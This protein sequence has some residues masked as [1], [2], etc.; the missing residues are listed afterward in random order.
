[1]YRYSLFALAA[2]LMTIGSFASTIAVASAM[3]AGPVAVA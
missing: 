2:A 1:M 3:I